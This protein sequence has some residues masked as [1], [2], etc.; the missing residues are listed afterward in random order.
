MYRADFT[1]QAQKDA[2]VAKQNGYKGRIDEL[3]ETV[4][5]APLEPTPGHCFEKLK[6]Y[7]PPIYTRRINLHHRFVYTIEPNTENEENENGVP[8]EG[9]VV[10]H[11]I[12]GH[13]P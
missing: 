10:V 7:Y 13:F 3:I 9:I 1:K 2:N 11:R 6:G 12:W 5:R 4:E 8:Y